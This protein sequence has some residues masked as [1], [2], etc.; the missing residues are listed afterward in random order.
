MKA[1]IITNNLLKFKDDKYALFIKKLTPDNIY[2]YIGIRIT[3]LR[4]YAKEIYK[5]GTYI[6]FIKEKHQYFE[7]FLLHRIILENYKDYF[8]MI[9]ELDKLLPYLNSWAL[10]DGFN[11][12]IILKNKNNFKYKVE[13]YFNNKNIYTVRFAINMVMTYYT[14]EENLNYYMEKINNINTDNY[15]LKMSIAWFFQHAFAK[16]YDLS[17][18]FFKNNKIINKD[19]KKYLIQKIK[20]SYKINDEQTQ[21]IIKIINK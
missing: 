13:Q 14:D 7:E 5:S 18:D 1:T 10:V 3:K 19:I 20:D 17:V 6:D 9:E 2:P 12:K 15:Y 8:L 4:K 16:Q 21:Y 11:N